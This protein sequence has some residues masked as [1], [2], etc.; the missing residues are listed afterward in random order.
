MLRRRLR[1]KPD[2]KL[3]PKQLKRR[4]SKKLKKRLSRKPKRRLSRRLRKKLKRRLRKK[5]L[6]RKP[7]L[8]KSIN[9]KKI[10][11]LLMTWQWILVAM[12]QNTTKTTTLLTNLMNLAVFP[13]PVKITLRVNIWLENKKCCRLVL[14]TLTLHISK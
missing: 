9:Q 8:L 11:P 2:W 13:P 5:D 12:S 3:R 1:K 10:S 4:P 6:K 14:S 7:R